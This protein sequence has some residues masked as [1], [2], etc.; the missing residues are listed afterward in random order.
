MTNQDDSAKIGD[1][2]EH[3]R[4]A[5]ELLSICF[6]ATDVDAAVAQTCEE[7]PA[8]ADKLRTVYLRMRRY[9]LTPDSTL[10][11]T[12]SLLP[13]DSMQPH[14]GPYSIRERIG[15]GGMGVV[16]RAWHDKLERDVAIKVVRPEF[17]HFAGK[18]ARFERE[19]LAIAR[20]SHPNIVPILEV[21]D[22][23]G[24][25]WFAMEYVRGASL[26]EVLKCM[27][28][29]PARSR[30]GGA[31]RAIVTAGTLGDTK[32]STDTYTHGS[33]FQKSWGDICIDIIAQIA[34]A[35]EHAHERGVL[36]RDLKPS[37][38]MVTADGRAMLLDFG[39]ARTEEEDQ[40]LTKSTSEIG[41]LP[42]MAPELL[43]GDAIPNPRLDVYGLGVSF[44]EILTG[45]NPYLD[46]TAEKTRARVL[47][48][49][50]EAPRH[51]NPQIPWDVETVCLTAMAPESERRYPGATAFREDLVRLQ[52]RQPIQ[53]KRPS[54]LLR[55]RRWQQR[56][57]VF[58][59]G[60][61]TALV[62]LTIS[63]FVLLFRERTARD[64]AQRLERYATQQK[65]LVE[66]MLD[67][68]RLAFARSL[69]AVTNPRDARR[70]LDR[71]SNDKR[72]W[73]WRHLTLMAD[74]AERTIQLFPDQTI[75]QSD[76]GPSTLVATSE[77]GRTVIVDLDTGA[78]R[79]LDLGHVREPSL[80]LDESYFAVS[81][82]GE[83]I[84]IVET[85]T[86][87]IERSFDAGGAERTPMFGSDNETLLSASRTGDFIVWKLPQDSKSAVLMT[88]FHAHEPHPKNDRIVALFV[89]H[90]RTEFVSHD[91][92]RTMKRWKM[93]GT[94]LSTIETP[95]LPMIQAVGSSADGSLLVV[96]YHSFF[97]SRSRR[98]AGWDATGTRSWTF[99][100]VNRGGAIAVHP[101]GDRFAFGNMAITIATV[102]ERD[103]INRL[104][105][106]YASMTGLYWVSNDR[107]VSASRDGT[108][109]VWNTRSPNHMSSY[110]AHDSS[111]T[112]LTA[113]EDGQHL[114]SGARNGSLAVSVP[115]RS[116][117]LRRI[118][119]VDSRVQAILEIGPSEVAAAYE[120]GSVRL[121]DIEA[122]MRVT[123]TIDV[124]DT[125]LGMAPAAPRKLL[126]V[127]GSA[128]VFVVDIESGSCDVTSVASAD[129]M[130]W[131]AIAAARDKV[132]L[133][134]SS[135]RVISAAL[136]DVVAGKPIRPQMDID[137][138][139]NV[140]HAV[141]TESGTR[142][143][144][145]LEEG[146]IVL[147]DLEHGT[148]L[149]RYDGH[150]ARPS[151]LAASR[152]GTEFFSCSWNQT[153]MSWHPDLE[154]SL[155]FTSAGRTMH[156]CLALSARE[157]FL[158]VGGLDGHVHVLWANKR[159]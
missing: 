159:Q 151:G 41:S 14:I 13:V 138:E 20:L 77:S 35:L 24:L 130:S 125:I 101:S 52:R 30:D 25:P 113:F 100:P 34:S 15:E 74:M 135:G 110:F 59:A 154:D 61:A 122:P 4:V 129:S 9:G 43:R 51:L 116:E 120:D 8:L 136:G 68:T 56:H 111:V 104:V 95:D 153:V 62:V 142:A 143:I 90:D 94:L 150:G 11:G 23:D 58:A 144:V 93:D 158:A 67:G 146:P 137:V 64:E 78:I 109:R 97:T 70:A 132:V 133:G 49:N 88:R 47:E 50:P 127:D 139:G 46:T 119:V 75:F 82:P 141:I 96:A 65:E 69:L 79:E 21:G 123:R 80:S 114:V 38:I 37:N 87:A 84:T 31:L 112:A 36:H 22:S 72:G 55:M 5:E 118:D 39:L 73:T 89:N 71:I 44:Y 32:T 2:L 106:N 121:V 147:L 54:L 115:A 107:L 152:D 6:E 124:A 1:D 140:L 126:T 26:A 99:K 157:D 16:Y 27:S 145:A 28:E 134:S 53:A 117:I 86:G 83:F 12:A 149:R 148:L 57:P 85:R 92:L 60:F 63:A 98:I 103:I 45:K 156:L 42:Y 105:G 7:N 19:A 91:R 29:T 33:L 155:F 108:C 48:G 128:N 131:S 76:A 40:K 18:R 10:E 3:S 102:D 66:R 17:L 81:G